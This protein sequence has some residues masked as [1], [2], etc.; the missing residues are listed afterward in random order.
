MVQLAVV[1]CALLG[2]GCLFPPVPTKRVSGPCPSPAPDGT[3]HVGSYNNMVQ[4]HSMQRVQPART[5]EN[6]QK[7]VREARSQGL[8]V[9]PLGSRHTVSTQ[10]CTDGVGIDMRQ[11]EPTDPAR[12]VVLRDGNV[13]EVSAG[14]RLHDVADQLWVHGKS[15]GFASIGFRGVSVGGVLAN[16]AHGSSLTESALLA[17]RVRGITLV[18]AQGE[19]K[20]YHWDKDRKQVMVQPGSP[21]IDSPVDPSRAEPMALPEGVTH[22]DVW[23]GLR[24]NLG[25]LGIVVRVE[26]AVD[27]ESL[28]WVRVVSHDSDESIRDIKA[29]AEGDIRP[30]ARPGDSARAPR[31]EFFQMLWYPHA[32]DPIGRTRRRLLTMCGVKVP[33]SL[34]QKTLARLANG[35]WSDQYVMLDVFEKDRNASVEALFRQSGTQETTYSSEKQQKQAQTASAMT[36]DELARRVA[37]E[38]GIENAKNVLR[39][40]DNSVLNP[41]FEGTYA[42]FKSLGDRYFNWAWPFDESDQL[43]KKCSYIEWVRSGG[44]IF[45]QDDDRPG[46][47]THGP[48]SVSPR[49]GKYDFT[50]LGPTHRLV[51]SD[52]ASLGGQ[53][54]QLD[55]EIA[56]PESKWNDAIKAFTDRRGK[57]NDVCLPLTGVFIRFSPVDDSTL[58]TH[59]ATASSGDFFR[60]TSERAMYL[61]F[62]IPA[63]VMPEAMNLEKYEQERRYHEKAFS[64]AEQLLRED[65][66]RPHFGKNPNWWVLNQPGYCGKSLF[67]VHR[68]CSLHGECNNEYLDRLKRFQRLID[69]FDPEG[70][71]ENE[72]A[73]EAGL[74]R[75]RVAEQNELR[76]SAACP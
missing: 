45:A 57:D 63:P 75:S 23:N 64:L 39:H 7:L 14:L 30:F 36:V 51:S 47:A 10:L 29:L 24:S 70:R 72:F 54:T 28:L 41:T 71:F 73:L 5:V 3:C 67:R 48:A 62:V 2:A 18:D 55:Y 1:S 49:C 42:S 11:L 4:C 6:L 22:E 15:I 61:D 16:G 27:E 31:C 43:I 60:S 74:V 58:L 19:L 25:M 59:A 17:H 53:L 13:A 68:E 21:S 44:A 35:D 20:H 8:R 56:V 33:A 12:G 69:V 34:D 40:F 32:K 46:S 76:Q 26:L 38:A 50:I 9:R 65:A 66:G 37:K 52:L